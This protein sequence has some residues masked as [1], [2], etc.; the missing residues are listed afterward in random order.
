MGE[1]DSERLKLGC[2]SWEGG[3]VPLINWL[4]VRKVSINGI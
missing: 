2:D 1:R 4:P 3:S